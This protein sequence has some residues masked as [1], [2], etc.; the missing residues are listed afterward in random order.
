[1]K[2][3]IARTKP[4]LVLDVGCN[5]GEYTEI[6]LAAGAGAAIGLERDTPAVHRAVFRADGLAQ[7]IPALAGRHPESEPGAGLGSRRTRGR[8]ATRLKPDALLCLALIHHLV[9]G[10][11]LPLDKVVRG[12]VALAP[13][14]HHRVR[15]A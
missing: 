4:A 14:R 1:M 12:L 2:E 8:C 3:F 11:G 15:T 10:E 13:T 7:T 9:L 6:A 5:A